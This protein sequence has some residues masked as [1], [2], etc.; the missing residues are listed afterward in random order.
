MNSIAK[1]QTGVTPTESHASILVDKNPPQLS[2][3]LVGLLL[4][5]L[6]LLLLRSRQEV[7]YQDADDL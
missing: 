3:L 4:Q 1:G 7:L 2:R 6:P 5:K